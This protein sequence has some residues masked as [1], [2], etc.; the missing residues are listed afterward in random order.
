MDEARRRARRSAQLS[1]L[2]E[3][4]SEPWWREFIAEFRQDGKSATELWNLDLLTR[5]PEFTQESIAWL[6]REA[7]KRQTNGLAF[8]EM[9]TRV[10]ELS[11]AVEPYK[12]LMI[13]KEVEE[14]VHLNALLSREAG[15]ST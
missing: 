10:N 5:V 11:G 4:R 3:K 6:Y 8:K 7:L 12:L 15:K 1:A 14:Q 2:R 9:L 13:F